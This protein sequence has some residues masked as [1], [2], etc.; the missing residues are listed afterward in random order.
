MPSFSRMS[1]ILADALAQK[2]MANHVRDQEKIRKLFLQDPMELADDSV[3]SGVGP[4]DLRGASVGTDISKFLYDD[5][6][7]DFTRPG[8]SP[9]PPYRPGRAPKR[10]T[11]P[12]A[13]R[14]R[15]YS[16]MANLLRDPDDPFDLDASFTG[17]AGLKGTPHWFGNTK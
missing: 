1:K 5:K 6:D 16:I 10:P 8:Y 14:K 15:N 12:G 9:P 17:V 13:V 4:A 11:G 2:A 7:L 3:I